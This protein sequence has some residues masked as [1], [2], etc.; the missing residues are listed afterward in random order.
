[1]PDRAKLGNTAPIRALRVRREDDQ[2][3]HYAFSVFLE[4]G[5]EKRVILSQALSPKQL[6]KQL[7]S[8]S[9]DIAESP[10]EAERQVRAILDEAPEQIQIGVVHSGWK[11]EHSKK[12]AFVAPNWCRGARC[13]SYIWLGASIAKDEPGT[14]AKWLLRIATPCRK[15][16]YLSFALMLSLSGP[17]RVFADDLPEGAVF[18]LYGDPAQEKPLQ[19][20]W[21]QASSGHP[22]TY[23]AGTSRHGAWKNSPVGTAITCSFSMRPRKPTTHE[24]K[25]VLHSLTHRI[26]EGKGKS[27][28]Q[29][30]QH[31]L[32]DVT[33]RSPILSTG[34]YSGPE[35]ARRGK[36]KWGEQDQAR[37]IS[38]PVPKAAA[39]GVVDL[40]PGED[41]ARPGSELIQQLEQALRANYGKSL[42]RWVKIAWLHR[43]RVNSLM[44]EFVNK[45]G[46]NSAH[47]RR[48]A[49][50]FGLST[51]PVP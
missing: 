2:S 46:A 45:V 47:D 51:Q 33:T 41:H 17:L 24:Q 32:P 1:M 34:N 38:I 43:D 25:V 4:D 11:N 10:A 20:R 44:E 9:S 49:R 37:F 21:R 48:I 15:S 7:R 6:V 39:G 5:S 12:P 27:R 42:R 18:H 35:M 22:R 40:A 26:A 30:V 29:S 14:H 3:L 36:L 28:S 8:F 31:S 23:L 50:K 16:T 19:R 13:S